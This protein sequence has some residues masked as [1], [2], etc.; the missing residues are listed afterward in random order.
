MLERKSALSKTCFNVLCFQT[1][2]G[3]C[4]FHSR[5][6]WSRFWPGRTFLQVTFGHVWSRLVTGRFALI[7]TWTFLQVT[8]GHGWSRLVTGRFALIFTWTFLQVTFG[9]VW[10]RLVTVGHGSLCLNLYLDVSPGHVWSRL[11]TVGHVSPKRLFNG[12]ES[13]TR[14]L[15]YTSSSYI[16][17]I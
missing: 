11:V 12:K 1:W 4:L 17:N 14:Y 6:C 13:R 5:F 10:S 15:I 3:R 9:H 16:Y 2:S 8:F 7:F